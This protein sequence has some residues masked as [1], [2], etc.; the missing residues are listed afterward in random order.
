[1]IG[2]GNKTSFVFG[3]EYTKNNNTSTI[4]KFSPIDQCCPDAPALADTLCILSYAGA[5]RQE[6]LQI[7]IFILFL[8]TLPSPV[9]F[10]KLTS[11]FHILNWQYSG[12]LLIWNNLQWRLWDWIVISS[13]STRLLI[14]TLHV[15]LLCMLNAIQFN[16]TK[17][18]IVI[19]SITNTYI[20]EQP[21]CVSFKFLHH[22][23][24]ISTYL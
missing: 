3:S 16:W 19:I 15:R 11:L 20:T 23:F 2:R 7:T 4:H 1:M 22:L 14:W 21:L 9:S 5:E 24:C 17:K 18:W 12:K 6:V 10:A 8:F 13:F